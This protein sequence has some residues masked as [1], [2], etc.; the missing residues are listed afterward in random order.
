MKCSQTY[1]NLQ[2][3]FISQ[4]WP[5]YR[6]NTHIYALEHEAGSTSDTLATKKRGRSL[7]IRT[8]LSE[9][10]TKQ[11]PFSLGLHISI[12]IS[13]FQSIIGIIMASAWAHVHTTV[14]KLFS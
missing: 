1:G 3:L 10:S 2:G 5:R 6:D 4:P 14:V 13:H 8:A 11:P 12:S 7:K 9:E